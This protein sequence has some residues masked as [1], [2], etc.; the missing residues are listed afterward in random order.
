MAQ[1]IEVT[2]ADKM[3]VVLFFL[4]IAYCILLSVAPSMP[5]AVLIIIPIAGN[6]AWISVFL[7]VTENLANQSVYSFLNIP[8]A[9]IWISLIAQAL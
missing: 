1:T 9:I 4:S 8:S 2:A 7:K 5:P 3:S 6:I